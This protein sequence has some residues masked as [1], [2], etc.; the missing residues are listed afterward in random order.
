MQNS[1]HWESPK[2]ELSKSQNSS[3]NSRIYESL[4]PVATRFDSTEFVPLS[5]SFL[6]SQVRVFDVSLSSPEAATASARMCHPFIRSW[7][8]LV[9][10]HAIT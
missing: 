7:L 9:T 2:L 4:K 1:E 5:R 10:K 6:A 8:L 3:T